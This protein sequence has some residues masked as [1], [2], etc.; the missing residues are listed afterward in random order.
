MRECFADLPEA[1]DNTL[2]IARRSAYMARQH[3]PI[4]PNFPVPEGLTEAGHLRAAARQGLEA[5]L[6]EIL[7]AGLDDVARE[8][9]IAGNGALRQH[10]DIW[11]DNT[12]YGSDPETRK[13]ARQLLAQAERMLAKLR[14][15]REP[16]PEMWEGMP[17]DEEEARYQEELA[18]QPRPKSSIKHPAT[19]LFMERYNARTAYTGVMNYRVWPLNEG[20]VLTDLRPDLHGSTPHVNITG[21]IADSQRGLGTYVMQEL[22]KLADTTGVTLT[23]T[24]EPT[25]TGEGKKK[26]PIRKL[27]AWYRRFGFEGHNHMRREPD[28]RHGRKRNPEPT[29]LVGRLKF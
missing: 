22:T 6:D 23:L 13:M 18:K 29:G 4:L 8:Y 9:A 16:N 15:A 7:D 19:R 21:I 11:E 14:A 27:R 26:I 24:P 25:E 20:D 17:V 3:D 28:V 1:I 12:E 5:R 2:V 10:T